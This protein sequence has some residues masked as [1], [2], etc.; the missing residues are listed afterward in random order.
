MDRNTH[1]L[2]DEVH[3]TIKQEHL[4]P[5]LRVRTKEFGH[6][7]QY[8]NLSEHDRCG[9]GQGARGGSVE[10]DR[11]SLGLLNLGK[12]APAPRIT[13]IDWQVLHEIAVPSSAANEKRW[14][15]SGEA[16]HK[17]SDPQDGIGLNELFLPQGMTTNAANRF[18]E[19]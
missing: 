1:A 10:S 2:L 5:H 12:D 13:L 7:R 16:E 14:V 8:I 19:D 15:G 6:H 17:D 9:H 18:R 11:G 3:D 4:P